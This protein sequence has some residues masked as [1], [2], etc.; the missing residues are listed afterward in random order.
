M[1]EEP[2]IDKT[3]VSDNVIDKSE[4][5]DEGQSNAKYLINSY[6]A[7]YT[8]D[9]LVERPNREDIYIPQFQRDYV[10]NIKQASKFIESLLLGLPVPGIFLSRDDNRK[11]L[12]IDGQQ[13]LKTLQRFYNRLFEDREFSLRGVRTDFEGKTYTTLRDEDRRQ[14]DDSILHATIIQQ[15]SPDDND[16]SVYRIFERLN[17]GGTKL[18]PQEIRIS[19][20][21][22]PFVELLEHLNK[23][24]SWRL[25]YG[26][27]SNRGK[28]QELILRF[29]ALYF[30]GDKYTKPLNEF[31]NTFLQTHRFL[32]QIPSSKF[33]SIFKDTID[34]F[35][36]AL[37]KT[38]FRSQ[39][40][41][42]AAVFDSMM[43]GLAKRLETG[44]I[45][46]LTQVKKVHDTL[47]Q[48]K[49]FTQLYTGPTTDEKAVEG[50]IQMAIDAFGE[51]L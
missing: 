37:G 17:T 44:P 6:G 35:S 25:I 1:T 49:D 39:R 20:Y 34:A 36:N 4:Q 47:I 9:S 45:K 16:S 27:L 2:E 13:R 41:L 23:Y 21:H 42:N 15:L 38:A 14:L 22:G 30:M 19:I 12:V 31:L 46:D 48:R 3:L 11:L 10:W 33:E 7:D 29:L 5:E 43:V 28:D 40:V 24:E 32:K 50:R 18:Q 26:A 51:I 8:I